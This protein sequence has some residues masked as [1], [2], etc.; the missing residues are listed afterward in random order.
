MRRPD[1]LTIP[2]RATCEFSYTFSVPS[3]KF[4]GEPLISRRFRNAKSK[5][6]IWW[7]PDKTLQHCC[8]Y[9]CCNIGKLYKRRH[10]AVLRKRLQRGAT[11]CN[12]QGFF[13]NALPF[14]Q[15]FNL[16]RPRPF[17][18]RTRLECPVAPPSFLRELP[19]R[20]QKFGFGRNGLD[21]SE[22]FRYIPI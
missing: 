12:G 4:R 13:S 9:F 5:I 22:R 8:D 10:F 17:I 18:I 19:R 6:P 3:R 14:G 2:M 11:R 21:M 7:Q 16:R 1:R 20:S 15:N